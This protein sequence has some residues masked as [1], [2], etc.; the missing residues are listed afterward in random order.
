MW[1]VWFSRQRPKR[2]GW[3]KKKQYKYV[4]DHP[5]IP[6]PPFHL[7]T[8][9]YLVLTLEIHGRGWNHFHTNSASS[10]ARC[11]THRPAPFDG[12]SL[13]PPH[14]RERKRG[15]KGRGERNPRGGPAGCFSNVPIRFQTRYILRIII[16]FFTIFF[17][18]PS[19]KMPLGNMLLP[20][21]SITFFP[22]RAAR[23]HRCRR[24]VL[25]AGP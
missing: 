6:F 19:P 14:G 1:D 12:P 5:V 13:P 22:D 16:I 24:R 7:P 4:I 18:L 23:M 17:R 11:W 3:T 9:A 21:S 2:G 8:T 20:H 10:R 25:E 15:E